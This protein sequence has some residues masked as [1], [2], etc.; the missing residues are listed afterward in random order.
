MLSLL[1]AFFLRAVTRRLFRLARGAHKAT[2]IA[3]KR[4][5]LEGGYYTHPALL[6]VVFVVCLLLTALAEGA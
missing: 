5:A 2:A 6:G 1:P 4:E 3:D